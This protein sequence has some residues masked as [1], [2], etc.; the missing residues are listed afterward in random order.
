MLRHWPGQ[1]HDASQAGALHEAG[2][3]HLSADKAWHLLGW[4]PRWDFSE[5]IAR[6][7]EWYRRVSQDVTA[8][9]SL[10]RE[11]IEAFQS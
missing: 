3:L 7:V 8:A 9:P 11:Q 4:R 5:T 10:T 6:T 1:W 2:R